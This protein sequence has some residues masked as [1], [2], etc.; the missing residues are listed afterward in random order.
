MHVAATKPGPVSPT[1]PDH[2]RRFLIAGAVTHYS[3]QPAWDRGELA[4][5]L[6][7][8]V[9]LFTEDLGYEHV[10][11]IG[12]DPTWR[13]I[14]DALRTFGTAPERRR[15]D[16]LVVYLA[17]HGDILPAGAGG[18]EHVLLP[19]D[20]VP[21]DLRR[22]AVRSAD[23][24]EWILADTP[25]ARLLLLMDTCFSGLGGADFTRNAV[26]WAGNADQSGWPDGSGVVVVSATQPRQEAIAGVFA[27]GFIR[28][29]RDPAVAGCA[30]GRLTVDAVI[31]A[32]NA[33][34]AVPRT[35]R[36]QWSLVLGNGEIPD[37]LPHPRLA[38]GLADVALR[39]WQRQFGH[40][41]LRAQELRDQFAPRAA[42][43]IGR[44][45]A[46]AD[47][48]YWLEGAADSRPRVVTGD[49]GS[50]KTAVLAVLAALR[51]PRHRPT[52]ARDGLP[53]GIAS[54]VAA[55]DVA[56]Y[57]GTLLSSQVLAALAA[58][59]GVADAD[60]DPADFDLGVARLLTALDQRERPLIAIIDAVDEAADPAHL[61]G[62]LL[63]PLI[64]QGRDRVRLLLGMRRHAC[65][66]L[67]PAWAR[68]C[69]VIDLD[70]PRYDDPGSL[71]A[72]VRRTLR[73]HPG[74][75]AAAPFADCSP[76]I[77]QAAASAIAAA[78]GKSFF[79]ARILAAT[80]ASQPALPE[81][82]DP[83][84][85][86]S[87]PSQAGPAMWRDL[88]SRLHADAGR[89]V[90]LL[91]PLAYAQGGGLPWEDIWPRL[92][93]V[94]S[95]G[96]SY[97]N[98]D[99]LWL[100][101][102]AGSYL[103]PGGTI[104]DRP[105]YA[106]YHR[107][108]ADHL[109]ADRDQVADEKAIATALAAHVPRRVSG[110]PDWAAAHPYIRAHL[111]AHADRGGI[112]D[113]LARDPG[114]LL[115]ADPPRLLA[116]LDSATAGPS[117]RAAAVAYRRARPFLRRSPAVE[118]LAYLAMAARY[119]HAGDLAGQAAADGAG[120]PWRPLWASWQPLQP[121][122]ELTGHDGEVTAI[123]AAELAGRP[124]IIS[125][126]SDRTIRVWDLATG[127]CHG[128]PLTG[129]A[130]AVRSVTTAWLDGNPVIISG[131]SDQTIRIWDLAQGASLG[132]PLTGHAGAVTSVA[133]ARLDGRPVI[134]SASS[135]HTVRV[136]DLAHRMLVYG[137]L[138]GHADWVT[139]VTATELDGRPVIISGSDDGTLQT[140][141]L[142]TGKPVGAPV[143]HESAVNAVAAARLG[144][145]CVVVSGADD[146]TLQ[147]WDLATGTA[148]RKP[149]PGHA[150]WVGSVVAAQLG[151]R[152]VVISGS[153]DGTVR[154]WELLTGVSVGSPL[155]GHAGAV[156]AVTVASLDG[157][158]VIVSGSDDGT[159]RVWDL[160]TGAAVGR[161]AARH[162][163]TVAAVAGAEVGG[164]PVVVSGGSDAT[165]RIWDLA[166]GEAAGV[167]LD[168]HGGRVRSLATAVLDGR[169]VVI[170]GSD[171][172]TIRVWDPAAGLLRGG[173]LVGHHGAV[174]AVA[175]AELD[176][177][178]VI[179][180][181]SDDQTLRVWDLA[182]GEPVGQPLAGHDGTVVAIATTEL[183]GRPVI[184]SGSSDQTIRIWDLATG[185]PAGEPL[186]SQG[187]WVLAVAVTRLDGRRV[188]I[189]GCDDGA[190]RIWDLA[191]GA[192]VGPPIAGHDSAV[193]AVAATELDGRPVV[194]SGS[195]DE[196]V[197]IWD[198]ATGAPARGSLKGHAGWVLSVATASLDGRPFVISGG[199][200]RTV[201]VWDLATSPTVGKVLGADAAGVNAVATAQVDGRRVVISA[202]RDKTVGVWDL[203]SGSPVGE[204]M[205]GHAGAVSAVTAAELDG[206][207]AIV[208]GG[209][210]G[211]IRIWDLARRRP[212]GQLI[213]S[214]DHRIRTVTA[215]SLNGRPLVI[216]GSDNG[217]V[218]VWDLATRSL[219]GALV[220]SRAG[221]VRCVTAARLRGRPVIVAG[222]S[223]ATIRIWDLETGRPVGEPFGGHDGAVTGVA[224]ARLDGRPVIVSGSSDQTIRVWDLATGT[225]T[226]EPLRAA[227]GGVTSVAAVT[228][229]AGLGGSSHHEA[230]VVAGIGP[231]AA[232]LAFST[233]AGTPAWRQVAAPQLASGVLAIAWSPPAT[234]IAGTD[235]GI[236]AIEVSAEQPGRTATMTRRPGP[237]DPA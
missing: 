131:S 133:A 186:A 5:D 220:A 222:L 116:A 94:L 47:I 191:T 205:A 139:A 117:A 40:E 109:R 170:S 16:Y 157:L 216:S 202:G 107:S 160:A 149:V 236:V 54:R 136:W 91:R 6:R 121:N 140:W 219:V 143:S 28:A 81:V 142:T 14:K 104:A 108:L 226:G 24:A 43:F 198:L 45:R 173:S 59:G 229:A 77:L 74:G 234:L 130:G 30:A 33:D 64:E 171:D 27:G 111:P 98:E 129:H 56:I 61:A 212:A 10:P 231:A 101:D 112:L 17:G 224:A 150:S 78:A 19:A 201:R 197:R 68:G 152:P 159:L 200:D 36:A 223:D 76:E 95:G 164:R 209:D 203:A 8:M 148:S 89:A 168:G 69:E 169:A 71:V 166:T 125:G 113:A 123:A 188:I 208:S 182:T 58:A 60:F 84:W 184:V 163:G 46:L 83:R 18:A 21:G 128:D 73:D 3:R 44:R 138:T 37:F 126:G 192:P 86:D 217:A 199:S 48:S 132:D 15:D 55:I 174:A 49:P 25:V 105:V 93:S 82:S 179:V 181:G 11:T 92:A 99:L 204:P 167:P 102:R 42:G 63:R 103:V 233:A 124:V 161:P 206:R 228:P 135:D 187:G 52:V 51:D 156:N 155:A 141:D 189:A 137:P 88:E 190:V 172:Q 32:M 67:G 183:D 7:Q 194:I 9:A 175:A 97:T 193:Y 134:I 85:R 2:G 151:N 158:P 26:A 1:G 50:G 115:A 70:A 75:A 162:S 221:G 185:K 79:V 177:R 213:S 225:L 66:H 178:L 146:G 144:G 120:G 35:Q 22:R 145:R 80:Q 20:A 119:E 211:T 31:N 4:G 196:I 12:L 41:H 114:F 153:G 90:E 87:L 147:T 227:L 232:V 180:S 65:R 13:Q 118:H 176:G 100:A 57:A 207:T 165:I 218:R 106:L 62:R 23:L 39:T 29:V 214:P 96:R 154:I 110:R 127:A 53:A 210:D 38:P 122:Q 235:R 34:P 230:F 72:L 215:A 195:D 237:Q